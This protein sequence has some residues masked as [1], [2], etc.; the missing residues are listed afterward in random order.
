MGATGSRFEGPRYPLGALVF[1]R[2]KAEGI[3]EPSTKP[4]LFCGWHLSPGLRYRGNLVVLDYEAVRQRSHLHWNAKIV[5]EKEVFLPPTEHIEFP[6]AKAAQVA[7]SEMADEEKELE[8][9][10][11]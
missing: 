5:H 3:A 9:G 10:D 7:M 11:L 2:V 6:L 4:G 8:E 1:Y